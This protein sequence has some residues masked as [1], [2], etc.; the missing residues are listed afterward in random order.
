MARTTR[1]KVEQF[2]I[3]LNLTPINRYTYTADNFASAI[4]FEQP[5]QVRD[6]VKAAGIKMYYK[7]EPDLVFSFKFGC[8]EVS[9]CE[10]ADG[11]TYVE[12]TNK[13]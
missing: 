8:G 10:A 9:I 11:M 3:G 7:N 1:W 4:V 6:A 12:L 5:K 13:S 2:L